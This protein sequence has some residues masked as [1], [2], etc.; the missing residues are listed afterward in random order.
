V[1]ALL[2]AFA[3]GGQVSQIGK[4]A[5][6]FV[7]QRVTDAQQLTT[8]QPAQK[9]A[10]IIRW[11]RTATQIEAAVATLD[12]TRKDLLEKLQLMQA[13]ADFVDQMAELRQARS[14]VDAIGDLADRRQSI[15]DRIR[16]LM[17]GKP[18]PPDM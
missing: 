8:L 10:L 16:D 18:S 1:K 7:H 9:D 12:T 4:S 17:T 14:I 11:G 2:V 5:L 3:D 6:D 13:K 15:S